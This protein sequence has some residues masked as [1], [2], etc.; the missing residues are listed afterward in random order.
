MNIEQFIKTAMEGGW[1]E[2]WEHVTK[3][4]GGYHFHDELPYYAGVKGNTLEDETILLDPK[5]WRAVG[6]INQWDGRY[7][8]EGYICEPAES[9]Q[10][11]FLDNLQK[12]MSLEEAVSEATL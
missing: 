5:S 4:M 8:S 6:K 1:G 10:H 7:L 9:R 2:G 3:T 12:G 11:M